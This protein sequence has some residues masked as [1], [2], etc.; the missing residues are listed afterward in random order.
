M[1]V[2]IRHIVP[3]SHPLR[4]LLLAFGG[5]CIISIF[6][7][8]LT[9]WYLLCVLPAVFLLVYWT[10]LDYEKIFY[11]LLACLP[12]STEL[13][14]SNGIGTD[15]PSEPL[16]IGLM[17]VYVLYVLRHAQRLD[18]A[19]LK[20][21]I[22]LL[23]LLHFGWIAIT[24]LTS[25]QPV[26]S[27]KFLLAKTWYVVTFYLLA[28]HLLK[29]KG[30]IRQFFAWVMIP[31][32][33]TIAVVLMRH[34]SY[35]FSFED[36][37]KVLHPFYRNHVNYACIIALFFPFAWYA[38][39]WYRHHPKVQYLL[40]AVIPFLLMATYL[41]YTRAAYVALLLCIGV[42]FIIR[43]RWMKY[44]LATAS[45]AAVL[46]FAYLAQQNNYLDY[47]P[48]YERAITHTEF[49]DLLAATY[50]LED[51]STMERVHRW[52][53]ASFMI[54]EKPV[55]G[56]GP[57][58]FYHFYHGYTVSRFRT[59]V[60]DNPEQSSA[61]NYYLTVAL[62][63]GILGLLLFLALCFYALLK[64]EQ[65]YHRSKSVEERSYL[66]AITLSFFVILCVLLINDLIET[67][68]VGAFFFLLLAML[69]NWDLRLQRLETVT[70][71]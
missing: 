47:A 7:A 70:T 17:G 61:H 20:H 65:L 54:V 66:L 38:V 41:S 3:G 31:L 10:I 18:Y 28:G 26:I 8:L 22:S 48:D 51:I 68:K 32:C 49:D 15:F 43:W 5:L 67:D 33:F 4:K 30:N 46:G 64:A 9:E 2:L 27:I 23:L 12:L 58:N 6:A 1:E 63:Q 19:F 55:V 29:T 56:F 21:P 44:A 16:M 45:V 24:T 62:E 11:L 40:I 60:S 35:G 42:Y 36:V 57:G 69:T 71:T 53:A 52:V 37:Y 39:Y 59:Y 25:S 13:Y 34:A 14:F 50:Q